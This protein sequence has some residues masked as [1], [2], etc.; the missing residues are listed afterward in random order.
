MPDYE[1]A[2]AA[3]GC[4]SEGVLA[5]MTWRAVEDPAETKVR[6]CV[7]FHEVPWIKI[8]LPGD[9]NTRIERPLN[10]EDKARWPDV[11][12]KF[13]AKEPGLASG[14]PIDGNGA[15]VIVEFSGDS[16]ATIE[17]GQAEVDEEPAR[18]VTH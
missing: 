14:T 3:H 5:I 4:D 2:E 16:D 1:H 13:E 18:V 11:W 8:I 10:D 6:N 7:T 17:L 15:V 12:R 9:K